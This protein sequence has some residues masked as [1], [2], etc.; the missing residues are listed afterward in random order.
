MKPLTKYLLPYGIAIAATVGVNIISPADAQSGLGVTQT[1]A[2]PPQNGTVT[3]PLGQD[4]YAGGNRVMTTRKDGTS[5]SGLGTTSINQALNKIISINDYG[6]V[7][8]GQT[9]DAPAIN[10]ALQ[11]AKTGSVKIGGGS[12]VAVFIPAKNCVINSVVHI[13]NGTSLQGY[14]AQTILVVEQNGQFLF[15]KNDGVFP[16]MGANL[17]DLYMFS[18]PGNQHFIIDAAT[19]QPVFTTIKNINIE[20]TIKYG[21]DA[22]GNN[23]NIDTVMLQ[24][25]SG[26]GI[27]EGFGS[28]AGNNT[29]PKIINSTIS[30]DCVANSSTCSTSSAILTQILDAGGLTLMN[31]DMVG[32]YIG[33]EILPGKYQTVFHLFA[34]NTVFSDSA[35][36]NGFLVDTTDSTAG[37]YNLLMNGVW[38]ANA[39]G[40]DVR[41]SNSAGGGVDGLTFSVG[42]FYSSN[43]DAFHFNVNVNHVNIDNSSICGTG[44]GFTNIFVEAGNSGYNIS[45][46]RM[47]E[48][49][50][51]S[52]KNASTGMTFAGNNDAVHVTGNDLTNIQYPINY[53]TSAGTDTKTSATI[54]GNAGQQKGIGHIAGAS[55]ITLPTQVWDN[56]NIDSTTGD[57]VLEIDGQWYGR[58]VTL[59]NT[60]QSNISFGTGK[61]ICNAVTVAPSGFV[62]AQYNPNGCWYLH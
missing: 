59:F 37:V 8:D 1:I 10:A 53:V 61:N 49:C 55:L 44:T 13:P 34:D 16:W 32:G 39:Q 5:F 35:L 28:V 17:S 30:G 45:N 60:T 46:N 4:F 23:V 12:V 51:Q 41:V 2:Q 21:I 11:A 62:Y 52:T 31:D 15:D 6:A 56:I 54:F 7:C 19:N 14:G 57:T 33:T 38:S 24:G 18:D 9:D 48:A 50:D 36:G 40:G 22:S 58:T 27:R 26:I 43:N 29:D 25:V 3:G 20:G 47:G 42:R